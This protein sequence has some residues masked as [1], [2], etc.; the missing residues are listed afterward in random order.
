MTTDRVQSVSTAD[1]EPMSRVRLP[2]KR[3]VVGGRPVKSSSLIFAPSKRLSLG[4]EWELGF[5][6]R[7]TR[8]LKSSSSE[9]FAKLGG[10][11]PRIKPE[12]FES[13]V[14]INT[15]I[16]VN[17]EEARQDLENSIKKVIKAADEVGVDVVS[18]GTHPFALYANRTVYPSERYQMLMNRERWIARRLMIFGLHVH[19]GMRDGEEAV[20]VLNGMLWWAPCLMALAA[21]S[22]YWQGVDTGLASARATV[23]ESSPVAGH[24]CTYGSW[25]EFVDTYASMV[26]ARAIRSIKDLWWDIRPQPDYGTIELRFCDALPTLRETVAVVSLAHG[27]ARRLVEQYRLG[28]RVPPPPMWMLRENKWRASRL[29]LRASFVVSEGGRT[30]KA[31]DLVKELV[32]AVRSHARDLGSEDSLLDVLDIVHQQNGASRQRAAFERRGRLDDVVSSL[33]RQLRGNRISSR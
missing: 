15:G 10:P 27:I 24:P 2:R 4:V 8:D 1:H 12:I 28:V 5:V 32:A 11:S 30:R 25:D 31:V 9:V 20:A 17:A 7:T 29:G 21:N 14:E 33:V 3:Q 22:P 6:D 13:M 26:R 16:C 18:G 23:F 19:L